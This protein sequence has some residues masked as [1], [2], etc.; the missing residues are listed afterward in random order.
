MRAVAALLTGTVSL[1]DAL[2]T[3]VVEEERVAKLAG[4]RLHLLCPPLCGP[5][6]RVGAGAQSKR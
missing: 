4:A 5:T 1:E 3:L 2:M 6:D